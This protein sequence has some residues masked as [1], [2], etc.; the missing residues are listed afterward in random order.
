MFPS[1]YIDVKVPLN[2]YN[3]SS[4]TSSS[5]ISNQNININ[6]ITPLNDKMWPS[7]STVPQEQHA[8]VLYDFIA[9]TTEDL[10]LK[11]A[12]NLTLIC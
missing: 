9:E 6:S 10:T 3:I 8:R 7:S 1:S 11:V 2:Q 4:S 12:A 5:I